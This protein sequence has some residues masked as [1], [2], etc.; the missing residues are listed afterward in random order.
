MRQLVSTA[1]A[2]V[3]VLKVYGDLGTFEQMGSDW[4]GFIAGYAVEQ[5][6]DVKAVAAIPGVD[7]TVANSSTVEY[8]VH[9]ADTTSQVTRFCQH[10][11]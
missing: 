4:V 10:P 2:L 7:G 3:M 1:F 9:C 5:G 6:C 8:Q 11:R